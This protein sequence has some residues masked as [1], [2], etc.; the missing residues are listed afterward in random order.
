MKLNMFE[1]ERESVT[2]KEADREGD[3][4]LASC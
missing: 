4:Y 1:N 3:F 2:E